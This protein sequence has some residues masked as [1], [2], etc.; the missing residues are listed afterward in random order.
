MNGLK[1]LDLKS[2]VIAS[3]EKRSAL[4]ESYAA[5]VQKK[6]EGKIASFIQRHKIESLVQTAAL[7][8]KNSVTI[9]VRSSFKKWHHPTD[10]IAEKKSTEKNLS[11]GLNFNQY[12]GQIKK[13]LDDEG[14]VECH[15]HFEEDS[16][17]GKIRMN[18]LEMSWK[19]LVPLTL[20]I[21]FQYGGFQEVDN[22][23]ENET[24]G[25]LLIRLGL[26]PRDGTKVSIKDGGKNLNRI[27]VSRYHGKSVT[28]V[29]ELPEN[30][31]SF[32]LDA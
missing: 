29:P 23:I 8:G 2:V 18:Q 26:N 14:D 32:D 17:S 19:S 1:M 3:R 13:W 24:F 30:G 12:V 28:L 11:I 21:N 4:R 22:F 20:I 5:D 31:D 7:Q 25:Q 6:L 16:K 27:K 9:P 15:I 10:Y